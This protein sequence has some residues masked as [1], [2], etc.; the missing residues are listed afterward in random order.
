MSK[1]AKDVL[2]SSSYLFAVAKNF[3]DYVETSIASRLASL[4][5]RAEATME[6]NCPDAKRAAL[7][8]DMFI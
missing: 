3:T 6:K 7:R 1:F 4:S 2:D 5:S 8:D